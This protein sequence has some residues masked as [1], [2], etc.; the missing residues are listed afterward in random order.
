[1]LWIYAGLAARVADVLD[2][3]ERLMFR[4]GWYLSLSRWDIWPP[5]LSAIFVSWKH[6]AR[7]LSSEVLAFSPANRVPGLYLAVFSPVL[8]YLLDPCSVYC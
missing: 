6:R 8:V 1:M 7:L 2:G 5:V 3:G 4:A